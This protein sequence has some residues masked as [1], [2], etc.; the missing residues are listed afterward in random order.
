[1]AFIESVHNRSS[2]STLSAMHACHLHH[3]YMDVVWNTG[4]RC[5]PRFS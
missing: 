4:G 2:P 5:G 1:M 3:T